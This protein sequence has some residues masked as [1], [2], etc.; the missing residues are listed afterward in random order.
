[1]NQDTLKLLYVTCTDLFT[2]VELWHKEVFYGGGQTFNCLKQ[3]D[4]SNVTKSEITAFLKQT[5]VTLTLYQI[6][7]NGLFSVCPSVMLC[8]SHFQ[9]CI[10]LKQVGHC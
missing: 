10:S 9:T 8:R 2:I 6:N 7:G 4:Q 3:K 5:L 1:M